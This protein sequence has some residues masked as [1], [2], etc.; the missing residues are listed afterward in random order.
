MEAIKDI[1]KEQPKKRVYG[2]PRMVVE[3]NDKGLPCGRNRVA[4]IMKNN[5]VKARIKRK[6]KQTTVSCHDN[7]VAPNLLDQKFDSD[8]PDKVYAADITFIWTTEGWLYLAIVLD[9]FSR[10]VIGWT[11]SSR[12]TND[13]VADALNKAISSRKPKKG[14]IVHS[15]R[16]SQY[17]GYEYRKLL[18]KHGFIQSMSG[19]GNCYDNAVAESFF[20]TIKTESV[21]FEKYQTRAQAK[22]SLF[23]YIELFYNRERRHSKLGYLS[24]WNYEQKNSLPET[25][26]PSADKPTNLVSVFSG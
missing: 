3:L 22:T 14:L 23:D 20:H 13:L 19:A 4:R 15:D 12:I 2:S 8:A 26:S 16:G 18:A 11:V 9:L 21:S 24:P 17:T 1:R 25:D 5:G 7:P 6:F 10:M